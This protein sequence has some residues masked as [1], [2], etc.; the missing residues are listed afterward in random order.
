M[1]KRFNIA[2]MNTLSAFLKEKLF[3]V[4]IDQQ[5]STRELKA[6]KEL[7]QDKITTLREQVKGI[8]DEKET[9]LAE[10]KA[11]CI[12]GRNELDQEAAAGDEGTSLHPDV[13]D[14]VTQSLSVFCVSRAFQ[15]LSS[16]LQKDDFNNS[17]FQSKRTPL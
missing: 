13:D 5:P 8:N 10:V 4:Y 11:V 6:D 15:K 9:F 12:Q 7:V 2:Y 17:S 1:T 3:D 16:R 14:A